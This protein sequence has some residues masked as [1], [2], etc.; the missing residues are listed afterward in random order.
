MDPALGRNFHK[1]LHFINNWSTVVLV[2][3]S[4]INSSRLLQHFPSRCKSVH[5][6]EAKQN[7]FVNNWSAVV[8]LYHFQRQMVL[9]IVYSKRLLQHGPRAPTRR[10]LQLT[11]PCIR[12]CRLPRTVNAEFNNI[13]VGLEA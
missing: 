1:S 7:P 5:L 2:L 9:S 12:P 8:L 6:V 3:I 4:V 11:I 10:C 13:D